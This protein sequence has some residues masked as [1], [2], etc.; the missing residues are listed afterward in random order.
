MTEI[1]VQ[2]LTP[3]NISQGLM[4]TQLEAHDQEILGLKEQLKKL[5]TKLEE[6]ITLYAPVITLFLYFFML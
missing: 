3:L 6:L 1:L 2:L 5:A 4:K